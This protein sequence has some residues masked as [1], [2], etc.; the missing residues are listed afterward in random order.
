MT[1]YNSCQTTALL[2]GELLS[3]LYE[4]TAASQKVKKLSVNY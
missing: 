2:K 3:H 1:S 4:K